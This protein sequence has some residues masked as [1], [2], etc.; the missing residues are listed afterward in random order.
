MCSWVAGGERGFPRI[1]RIV[2]RF[3]PLEAAWVVENVFG[4]HQDGRGARMEPGR[5]RRRTMREEGGSAGI[6]VIGV[7]IPVRLRSG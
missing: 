3:H 1:G 4:S 6:A 7:E 2:R 5:P